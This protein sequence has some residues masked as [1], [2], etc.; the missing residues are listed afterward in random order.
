MRK[1]SKYLLD[2]NIFSYAVNADW[3][4]PEDYPHWV[5]RRIRVNLER[6]YLP[7]IAVQEITFGL[8]QKQVAARRRTKAEKWLRRLPKLAYDEAAARIAGQLQ[9]E[10]RRH[11][12]VIADADLQ[13]ASIA[14]RHNLTLVT[15]NV[16]H[17]EHIQ[18]LRIENWAEMPMSV[19]EF[20]RYLIASI[21]RPIHWFAAV[22]IALVVFL[23][24]V[25]PS[26]Y[27]SVGVWLFPFWLRVA[28]IAVIL[29]LGLALLEIGSVRLCLSLRHRR[30]I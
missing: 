12:I 27:F 1:R 20:F 24:T 19:E 17:F 22:A 26:S 13:I 8:Y 11:G 28:E 3:K 9:A 25:P 15:H 23:V 2:T 7:S 16:K 6:C 29:G 14:L 30:I 18:G 4:K 21:M 5:S 10:L